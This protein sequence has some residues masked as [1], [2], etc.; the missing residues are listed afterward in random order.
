MEYI[1]PEVIIFIKLLPTSRNIY[2]LWCI[3]F[4]SPDAY[5]FFS[6]ITYI[7]ISYEN[8]YTYD[9]M[10]RC[11][12][13]NNNNNNT[14][15]QYVNKQSTCQVTLRWG[16]LLSGHCHPSPSQTASPSSLHCPRLLPQMSTVEIVKY[17]SYFLR[18]RFWA[19]IWASVS[20]APSLTSSYRIV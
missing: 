9:N 11:T 10:K 4:H 1:K 6:N 13:R 20:N 5:Q 3:I 8:I 19:Q 12:V 17:L 16:V 14:G 7:K 2:R 15:P 18:Y